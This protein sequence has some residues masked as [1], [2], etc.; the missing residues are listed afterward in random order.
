MAPEVPVTPSVDQLPAPRPHLGA[1]AEPCSPAAASTASSRSRSRLPPTSSGLPARNLVRG[2]CTGDRSFYN[3]NRHL[4]PE[5]RLRRL[6]ALCAFSTCRGATASGDLLRSRRQS[7]RR[8]RRRRDGLRAAHRGRA[9]PQ[10]PAVL[11]RGAAAGPQGALPVGFH[12]KALTMVEARLPGRPRAHAVDEVVRRLRAA[13]L[14]SCP[15]G[16]PRSS[17]SG[18]AR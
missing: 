10:A 11:L 9:S 18:C 17:P 12:L 14:D 16:A 6:R 15:G 2:G 13:G 7:V 1:V 5:Q 4:Q 8:A 3:I